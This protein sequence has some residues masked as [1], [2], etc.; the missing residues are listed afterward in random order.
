MISHSALSPGVPWDNSTFFGRLQKVIDKGLMGASIPDRVNWALFSVIRKTGGRTGCGW[1][2]AGASPLAFGT[3]ICTGSGFWLILVG[4]RY[5]HVT[6][7]P[8][9]AH[10]L[11]F[12]IQRAPSS[13]VAHCFQLRSAVCPW[14]W[15][16]LSGHGVL[17]SSW[18]NSRG[19][20]M[21]RAQQLG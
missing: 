14:R 5:V 16:I 21:L 8:C 11:W 7:T 17:A 4:T 9:S 2:S 13:D 19:S 15:V 18:Q 1:S 12:C 3:L 20:L 6:G 10:V